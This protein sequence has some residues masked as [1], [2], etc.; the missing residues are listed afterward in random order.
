MREVSRE[1]LRGTFLFY[2]IMK[3]HVSRE[4]SSENKNKL[5]NI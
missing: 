4:T 2:L 3:Q 5:W 1:T